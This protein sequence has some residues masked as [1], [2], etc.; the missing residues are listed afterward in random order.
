MDSTS[1]YKINELLNRVDDLAVESLM[2]P[3]LDKIEEVWAGLPKEK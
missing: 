3:Y 1:Q 2:A